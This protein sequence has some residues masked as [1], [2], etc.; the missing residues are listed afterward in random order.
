MDVIAPQVSTETDHMEVENV[1]CI[2]S[3]AGPVRTPLKAALSPK[4]R[5]EPLGDSP[6]ANLLGGLDETCDGSQCPDGI[7]LPDTIRKPR[8]PRRTSVLSVD[9]SEE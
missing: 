1:P 5:R 2:V 4:R 6:A 9:D 7:A 3:D 8:P